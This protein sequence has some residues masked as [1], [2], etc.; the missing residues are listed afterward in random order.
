M[1]DAAV[2][3]AA[4]YGQLF[5]QARTVGAKRDGP[6]RRAHARPLFP[7]RRRAKATAQAK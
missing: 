7:A 6:Q 5:S 1:M 2:V 4:F 3:L